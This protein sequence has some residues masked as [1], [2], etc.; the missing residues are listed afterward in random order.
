[1]SHLLLRQ[2]TLAYSSA[3]GHPGLA[4]L[5]ASGRE[6]L[7]LSTHPRPASFIILCPHY[8]QSAGTD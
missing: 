6:L 5:A 7:I 8:L 2:A 4:I 1:M 3:M